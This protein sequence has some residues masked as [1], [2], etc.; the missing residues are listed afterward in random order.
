MKPDFYPTFF[1]DNFIPESEEAA[2]VYNKWNNYVKDCDWYKKHVK[3]GE[4]AGLSF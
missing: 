1:R 4:R 3:T 2:A